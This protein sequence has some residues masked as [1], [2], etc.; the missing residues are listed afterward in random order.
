M[1]LLA[2]FRMQWHTETKQVI[3]PAVTT[4]VIIFPSH[5]SIAFSIPLIHEWIY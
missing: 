5:L 2:F 4:D 3:A 1:I